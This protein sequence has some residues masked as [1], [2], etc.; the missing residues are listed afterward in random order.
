MPLDRPLDI[1]PRPIIIL[2]WVL[3]VLPSLLLLVSGS[4]KIAQ[5]AP[6]LEQFAKLGY[7]PHAALPIGLVEIACVVLLLVPKTAVTGA[8][9]VTG[10]MGG[11]IATHVRL[12]EPFIVQA[13]LPIVIWCGLYLREPRLRA[14]APWRR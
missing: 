14:L 4:M 7:R 13:L 5:P 6:F 9:L 11:A 3:T 10:Y 2:G 12:D 8:I 1:P